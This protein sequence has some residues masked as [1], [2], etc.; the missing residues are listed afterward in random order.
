MRKNDIWGHGYEIINS[1]SFVERRFVVLLKWVIDI[2]FII[3]KIAVTYK[4]RSSAVK[5]L[6]PSN[7][8]Y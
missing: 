8:K 7:F 4:E 5:L 2:D 6:L 1:G 3:S